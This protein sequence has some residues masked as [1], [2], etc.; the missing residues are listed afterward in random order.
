MNKKNKIIGSVIIA[1][2]FCVFTAVGIIKAN[3]SENYEDIFVDNSSGA[4]SNKESTAVN[5][6]STNNSSTNSKFVKVEIKGEVQKPGVYNMS[7]GS[8]LEDLILKAGGL[9]DKADRDKL[10]SLARKLRDEECIIIA[11]KT[12]PA[13]SIPTVSV[14]G[15]TS[16]V[17]SDLININ[18]ADEN[19][20]E[21]IPG[22]GPV[23]AQRIIDYRNKNGDFQAIED[24]K[25]ISGVGEK[26]FEKM[27]DKITV[28]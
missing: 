21:K 24:M 14:T 12:T 3:K 25:N 19:E 6:S 17:G 27:K 7:F 10:P 11:D 23:M 2:I 5:S 28:N 22:V 16:P 13:A 18:T 15:T 9:T 4:N 8:R 26:T 20:L 1:V